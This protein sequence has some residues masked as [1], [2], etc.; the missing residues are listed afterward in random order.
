MGFGLFDGIPEDSYDE[1]L[2]YLRASRHSFMKGEIIQH[3]G[4]V[5]RSAGLVLEGTI[6]CSYQDSDFNKFN[7][8]HFTAGELFGESMACAE[9]S[10]SPMQISALTDCAV[11]FLD[12]R[13]LYDSGVKYEYSMTIA[14]NLIRI[15]SAQNFF[16][17]QKVRILS[18]KDMRSKI[19][20]YLQSLKPDLDGTI[21]LPFTKSALS[22]FLCVN[23]T[24]LSRELGNMINEGIIKMN[25]RNFTLCQ[26]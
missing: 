10:D 7:M 8:N 4:S 9:V 22:E 6:E 26:K 16:M 3:I 5:F 17:N 2:R 15:I 13:V 24:A 1:A 11:M 14:V 19:L 20:A 18:R 23:R 21:K 25:G 12:L